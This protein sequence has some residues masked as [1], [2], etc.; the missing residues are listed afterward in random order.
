LRCRWGL[1]SGG[2]TALLL[3]GGYTMTAAQYAEAVAGYAVRLGG[4]DFAAP[5]D[6]MCEPFMVERT[7]LSVAEHQHRTVASYLEL[8]A[9]A[10]D[11]PFIP[12]VQ[13]WQLADYLACLELYASAGVDLAA[14][15]RVGLGSVCRRQSTG[16]I[17]VIVTELA[18]RGLRL[19]GFGIKTSGLCRAAG[20]AATPA[21]RRSS[22]RHS[23]PGRDC[24][25][26]W[27]ASRRQA[28][29]SSMSSPLTSRASRPRVL[30]PAAQAGDLT[31]LVHRRVRGITARQQLKPVTLGEGRQRLRYHDVADP[32]CWSGHR[33]PSLPEERETMTDDIIVMPT[34]SGR[35]PPLTRH[36]RP[37]IG[38]RQVSA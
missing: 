24:D 7:G 22:S 20:S 32:A 37:D 2:F 33:P 4:L 38:I 15:P 8:R 6:W 10:P 14:L 9:L 13:G 12:V 17:A 30:K 19:H 16:Q 3:D 36:F 25:R 11:L 1:D 5:M 35:S 21:E 23:R 26:T 29:N 28:R 27:P 31:G 18:R 34:S